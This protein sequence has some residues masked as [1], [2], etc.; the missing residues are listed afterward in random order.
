MTGPDG[1]ELLTL[2]RGDVA[3]L[4]VPVCADGSHL[5]LPGKS[6]ILELSVPLLADLPDLGLTSRLGCKN[7]LTGSGLE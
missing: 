1:L 3:D 5:L 2:L 4:L 6:H 7:R